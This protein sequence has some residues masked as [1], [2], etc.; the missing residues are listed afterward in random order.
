M[1]RIL[2][3]QYTNPAVYP[4]L[5][6]SSRILAERGW[7]ALFLGTGSLGADA[8]RF[9]SHERIEVRQIPISPTGWRQKL[10]YSR[11]VLWVLWWTLRWK[12]EWTYASDLL[13]CPVAALSNIL[14]G[15]RVIYHEHDSPPR[16]KE[17]IFKKLSFAA[18][19]RLAHRAELCVLPNQQRAE[20]FVADVNE[21]ISNGCQAPVI[22]WNCPSLEEVAP[23]RPAHGGGD[24]WVLYAGSIVPARLPVSVLEALAKLP[25]RVKIRVIGYETIGHRGYVNTLVETAV[26]LG[27]SNRVEYLGTIPERKELL[28]WYRKCDVGLALMPK[29]SDDLNEQ[30]MIGASNKPFDYLSCGLALLVSDL[31]DWRAA[32]VE[33]GYGLTCDT[34]DPESIAAALRWFLDHP[35]EMRAMGERGRQRIA[36]EWN[37]EM[38][39]FPVLERMNGCL[40]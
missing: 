2:Y 17:S 12:P 7:Q 34:D 33:T 22:V 39:F 8:L 40:R 26:Q 16:S 15:A 31:P 1:R 19:R 13:S 21:S 9:E 32:Y 3:I 11:F 28:S 37:Y 27:I 18:R 20:R 6:H 14:S 25:E 35:V 10:H 29:V 36:T 4:P 24:L 5:E 38:K 30:A 23:P